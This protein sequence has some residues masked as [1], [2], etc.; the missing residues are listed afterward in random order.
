MEERESLPHRNR[1][2]QQTD[3]GRMPFDHHEMIAALA[4]RAVIID[5]SNDDYSNDA[6]GDSIGFEGARP[7]YEFLGAGKNLAFNIRM[8]GGGHSI[9][10]AHRQNLVSFLNM[11]FYGTP[12]PERLQADLYDNPYIDS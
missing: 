1:H 8:T 5:T 3:G 4:P 2:E 11:V 10:T 6:E 7:V 9:G 12:L